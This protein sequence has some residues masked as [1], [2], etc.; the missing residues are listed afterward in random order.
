VRQLCLIFVAMFL[1]SC[2][3]QYNGQA[4]KKQPLASSQQSPAKSSE[5]TSIVDG[6]YEFVSDSTN[7]TSPEPRTERIATPQW[8]GLWIFH[9]GYFSQTLMKN[10]RTEWTP[11]HFPDDARKVGFDGAAGRYTVAGDAMKLHYRLSFYP[12][13][14]NEDRTLKYR[15]ENDEL[16]LTEELIPGREYIAAGQR[17]TVLR[18]VRSE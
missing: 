11:A 9:N 12:G 16:I 4:L 8:Q 15:F 17:V 14:T 2:A 7:I 18:R 13:R 1:T 3:S 10:D 5:E 6:I